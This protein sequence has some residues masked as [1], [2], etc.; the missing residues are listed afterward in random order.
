M[1]N[2]EKF[3]PRAGCSSDE[4]FVLPDCLTGVGGNRRTSTPFGAV[5]KALRGVCEAQVNPEERGK[6]PVSSPLGVVGFEPTSPLGQGIL[7]PEK[8]YIPSAT[9]GAIRV[10]VVAGAVYPAP[11]CAGMYPDVHSSA[12]DPATD[13][14]SGYGAKTCLIRGPPIRVL[15]GGGQRIGLATRG[16][17]CPLLCFFGPPNA[18]GLRS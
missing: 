3:R 11:A 9:I 5:A 7:S 16:R 10:S 18:A 2:P 6:E 17:R 8:P 15:V 14:R 4:I 13:S 12:T 1:C